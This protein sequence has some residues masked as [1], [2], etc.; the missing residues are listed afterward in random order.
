MFTHCVFFWLKL[1]LPAEETAVF[2]R[3]LRSLIGTPGVI[4]GSIGVPAPTVRSVVERSYSY[5]L[6]LRF[7]DKAAH[8]AY[9]VHPIHDQFHN[10][11]Q[12]MW[13]NV[14]V[15]DFVDIAS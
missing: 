12:P 3:G 4:D 2:E 15:Y 13:T 1:S 8:D 6:V 7:K 5:G 11:C 14:V 9:Q 10:R